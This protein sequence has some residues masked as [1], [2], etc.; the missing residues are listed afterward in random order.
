[1]TPFRLRLTPESEQYVAEWSKTA[2]REDRERIAQ[3]LETLA[4]GRWNAPRWRY[5]EYPN[6]PDLFDVRPDDGLY[7]VMRVQI[8]EVDG[9]ECAVVRWIHRGEREASSADF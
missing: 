2:T 5:Q 1:M 4:D 9:Q 7:V 6:D 3:F 8:N